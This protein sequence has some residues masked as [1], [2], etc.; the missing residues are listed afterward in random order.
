MNVGGMMGS[1][2]AAAAGIG[3]D[4]ILHAPHIAELRRHAAPKARTTVL[5][6]ARAA[7]RTADP[8]DAAGLIAAAAARLLQRFPVLAQ[9]ATTAVMAEVMHSAVHIVRAERATRRAGLVVGFPI[10]LLRAFSV[11]QQHVA[12]GRPITKA[13]VRQTIRH[14]TAQQLR[15]A[16]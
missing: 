9:S 16:G 11:L 15:A 6:L 8:V 5:S 7:A 12:A 3:G 1:P 14:F 4:P 13:H 2:A 10:V